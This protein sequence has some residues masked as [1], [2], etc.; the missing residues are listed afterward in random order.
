MEAA[1]GR[2]RRHKGTHQAERQGV[3]LYDGDQ[4]NNDT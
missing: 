1:D 4:A 2:A 3:G